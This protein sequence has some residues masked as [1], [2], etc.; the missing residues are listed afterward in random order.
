VFRI[1]YFETGILPKYISN[2]GIAHI[3]ARC[4]SLQELDLYKY[5]GVGDVGLAAVANGCPRLKSINISYCIH[6]TDNGLT[7]LAQMQ[8]L[9]HL[10]IEVVLGFP[11][12]VFLQS[13]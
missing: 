3:G 5:V 2:E 1:D 10:E 13:L 9:H 12:L 11:L 7:S 4:S 8:K 6:V